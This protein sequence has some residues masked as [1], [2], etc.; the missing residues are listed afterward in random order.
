MA[1]QSHPCLPAWPAI[2]EAEVVAKAHLEVNLAN[3][4]L[5]DYCLLDSPPELT[6]I[7]PLIRAS[8]VYHDH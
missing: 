1:K 6:G 5:K 8:L 7:A 4:H 2:T 3:Q